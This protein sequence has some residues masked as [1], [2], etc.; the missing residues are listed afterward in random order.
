MIDFRVDGQGIDMTRGDI[1]QR[2][3]DDSGQIQ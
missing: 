2:L 1:A 3:M